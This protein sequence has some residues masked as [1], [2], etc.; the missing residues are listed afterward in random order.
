[1]NQEIKELI[2]QVTDESLRL[3]IQ[4]RD[5]I[6]KLLELDPTSEEVAYL[7]KCA[8]KVAHTASKSRCGIAGAIGVDMCSC[9][10]NCKFCSFGTEWGLVKDEVIYTKEEVIEMARAYV[11]AGV[12]TLT[13][14]STEFYDLATL[15][16]WLHDIRAA[17]PGNYMI[18]LNVGEM[19]PAMAEAAYQAGATSAYHVNRMREGIDT[20]FDPELREQTIRAIADSPLRWGTCIEPIGCEHTNEE[21]ADKILYNMSLHPYGEGVFRGIDEIVEMCVPEGVASIGSRAFS[22]CMGLRSISLPSTLTSL[23]EAVFEHCQS[24]EEIALPKGLRAVPDGAFQGC[25]ALRRV[26]IP[27]SVVEIGAKA[28]MNCRALE[29]IELHDSVSRIGERA[30]SGCVELK[31]ARLPERLELLGARAFFGC[32]ELAEVFFPD[33]VAVLGDRAFGSCRALN[34]LEAQEPLRSKLMQQ[35]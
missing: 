29:V 30:F 6:I 1:M 13:L 22:G 26:V 24:L 21:L 33:D 35:G 5:V 2:D 8:N 20:P 7:R 25:N 31:A 34:V 14:R 19:T 32:K 12:T 18:N 17:V 9:D 23:G 3:A 4:P 10:M 27:D 15:T 11:E 28:F 16:E